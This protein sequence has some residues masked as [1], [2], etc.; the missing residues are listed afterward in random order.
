MIKIKDLLNIHSGA[1]IAVSMP[2]KDLEYF[3]IT[4]GNQTSFD[5]KIVVNPNQ[6]WIKSKGTGDRDK[7]RFATDNGKIHEHFANK[8]SPIVNVPIFYTRDDK[9][10]L[11]F[12]FKKG[13]YIYK[14]YRHSFVG[15]NKGKLLYSITNK[16]SS[17][18]YSVSGEL[19]DNL[20]VE[21]APH[22]YPVHQWSKDKG[23]L[24]SDIPFIQ[25]ILR[26][27]GLGAY[28]VFSNCVVHPGSSLY[29]SGT[30]ANNK[31]AVGYYGKKNKQREEIRTLENKQYSDSENEFLFVQENIIRVAEYIYTIKGLLDI[32]RIIK[33]SKKFGT[34]EKFL[35]TLND[36][37]KRS[38]EECARARKSVVKQL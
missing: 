11:G 31:F 34:S 24:K 7:I 33:Q 19:H 5:E 6:G 2:P 18:E 3:I 26:K 30:G 15:M 32:R 27:D 14:K 17:I 1:D 37:Y 36:Q 38:K 13:F 10:R 28:A 8:I 29:A 35:C 23:I 22:P 16:N 25:E 9:H 20:V 12:S 21:G 4:A